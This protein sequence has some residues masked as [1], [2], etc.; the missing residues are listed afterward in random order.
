MSALKESIENYQEQNVDHIYQALD[1]SHMVLELTPD[2][3]ITYANNNFLK[4]VEKNLHEIK[5]KHL[6]DF[7]EI[8]Q[9]ENHYGKN[10]WNKIKNENLN[11]ELKLTNKSG[12][13]L[14]V[15]ASIIPIKDHQNNITKYIKI[16]N[17]ITE[18][19]AEVE[20]RMAIMN[21]TSIVS[22][23]DLKGNILSI[24]NKFCEVSQ[25]DQEELIGQPHNTTRHPDVPKDTFKSMWSTIG[26]GKFFRGVIKNRKK[27][28]TPYYVDAVIAPVLGHNGKPKKYI[29]V[30]YDITEQEIEKHNMKGIINAIDNSFTYL[31]LD[32][33]GTIL[34]ANENFLNILQFSRDEIVGKKQSIL[35]EKNKSNELFEAKWNEIIR[36]ENYSEV[37]KR[38]SKHGQ[39]V[40]LQS[41]YSAVSDEM[42]RVTKIIQI[43][44]DVT[45][46]KIQDADYEGQIAAINRAQAVIEFNL[47]G[48]IQNANDNFLQTLGYTLE[49]IT[50]KHHRIFCDK[51]FYHSPEYKEFWNQLAKGEFYS[52]RFKRIA[53][54]GKEIWIQATYNP[55]FDLNG[56]PIKVIKYATDISL[57][58]EV[59][60]IVTKMANDISYQAHEIAEKTNLVA[61]G[62]QALGATTEEMNASIEELTASVNSIA[63][64]AKN[65]DLLAKT[66]HQEATLGSEAIKKAIEA[67]DLI[68]KSTEDISEIVTVISEIAS[69]TN[70]LAFNAAIEAARAGEH[71]L[72]FSVVADEV[73]KLAE[74]SSQ[75][76]KEISKL[77]NES[78]KRVN[79]GSDISKKAGDA[80]EKI[81]ES[82]SKTT[83]SI[84]EVSYAAEE[85]LMAAKEISQAIQEV[86]E[87]TENAAAATVAIAESTKGLTNGAQGLK[88]TVMK[89]RT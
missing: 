31:E 51:E 80:F 52:G 73:R 68:S 76:T 62:A 57:Q 65:S 54:N 78:E 5:G 42:G 24:N 89:F 77:I 61:A 70:L 36:G 44:T 23:A 79:N 66:T 41:C 13:D 55:I 29:G 81:V 47:E 14:W 59:E 60:E 6:N 71:G 4:L 56:K 8:T 28:G 10:F 86:A 7:Y 2:G 37:A 18:L 46:K 72:G 15:N 84:S 48:I 69:Q 85:Q 45:K 21:E 49:E 26:R 12:N 43:G 63:Q 34:H 33:N 50:G 3:I 88:A 19:K 27:D 87:K 25:Y 16:A 53:K 83:Q 9:F 38:I 20:V 32:L 82:V 35:N 67:M 58:V 74:R 39:E 75:A 64:N 11:T 30:R 40:W 22:E 17:D 1:Q